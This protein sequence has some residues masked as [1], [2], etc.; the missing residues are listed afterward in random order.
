MVSQSRVSNKEL[1]ITRGAS[2]WAF[3]LKAKHTEFKT[4]QR[5]HEG[6]LRLR[7]KTSKVGERPTTSSLAALWKSMSDTEKAPF[8]AKARAITEAN[9][10]A[11]RRMLQEMQ[12]AKEQVALQQLTAADDNAPV[13]LVQWGLDMLQVGPILGRGTYGCVKMA[14]STTTG[15]HFARKFST[16]AKKIDSED[17]DDIGNHDL[18]GE[19]AIL[20]MPAHPGI[21]QYFGMVSHND[22][23][24]LVLELGECNILQFIDSHKLPCNPTPELL[25]QRKLFFCQGA[26]ALHHLHSVA[27]LLHCDI[28]PNNFICF[29]PKADDRASAPKNMMMIKLADFGLARKFD[30]S[31]LTNPSTVYN[32]MYRCPECNTEEKK[33]W[34]EEMFNGCV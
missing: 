6:R 18:L 19:R 7:Q 17:V 22:M 12:Q 5:Q 14:T 30:G 26:V 29:N 3:F 13:E 4:R 10:E 20:R 9:K 16:K 34:L 28:K 25:R 8:E 1:G 15:L 2:S 33:A 31:L 21:V 23:V 11:R 32:R 24:G 27:G